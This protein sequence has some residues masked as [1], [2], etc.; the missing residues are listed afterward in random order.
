MATGLQG[1]NN[2]SNA[3]LDE[4][5]IVEEGGIEETDGIKSS[6]KRALRKE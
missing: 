3:Q 6:V 2:T 4:S 1:D 5:R